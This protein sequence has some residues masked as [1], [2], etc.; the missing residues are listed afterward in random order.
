MKY[1]LG[2]I[3]FGVMGQAI[4]T[5]ALKQGILQPESV[6]VYDLDKEKI[7]SCGFPVVAASS[8]DEL[9]TKSDRVFFAVKPQQYVDIVSGKDFSSV[10]TILTIM[11]GVSIAS[12]R[13]NTGFSG[14]IVRVMPNTP[15][16]LGKGVC[17]YYCDQTEEKEKE[18]ILHILSSCG[19]VVSIKENQF[20][21]VTSVSGSGPAYVYTFA[22]GMIQG[23]MNGGLT[24]EQAKTLALNTL[25]GAAELAKYSQDDLD[26]LIDRVC[27]KGG[28]TI[29]AIKSY[30]AD[31]LTD[32][33]AKGVDACRKRSEELGKAK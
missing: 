26:T 11:A 4:V 24:Y 18:F 30:R 27:S 13:K 20:D 2:V 21:A 6:L 17:A 25:C 3:G 28:T 1:S 19:D 29:E 8:V 33:I 7:A 31:G 14:G 5:R 15:C 9:L 16:A 12:L 23:G 22:Q 32:V 10:K